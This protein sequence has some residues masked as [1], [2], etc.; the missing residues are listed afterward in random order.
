MADLGSIAHP[1]RPVDP[2][3]PLA[4]FPADPHRVLRALAPLLALGALAFLAG[5][6]QASARQ[7]NNGVDQER[8]ALLRIGWTPNDENVERRIRYDRL[9]AF[10]S[11][12]LG[13]PVT[14]V[15][16]ASYS[17]AIEA[18]RA[19]KLEVVGL[20]PFAYLIASSKQAAVP[21]VAPAEP[22]GSL[23]SYR[24][25][26]IVPPDSP[27]HTIDDLIARAGELTLSWTDPASTSGHLVPRAYL[28]DRGLNPE[29]DFKQTVFSLS[30]LVSVMTVVSHKVDVAAITN[31]G[32]ERL[33]E[34][35]RVKPGE[36]R[37]IWESEPICPSIIA[38]RSTLPPAFIEE[39][40]QAYLDFRHEDPE[41][42]ALF[43][44]VYLVPGIHWVPSHDRDFD[45]LRA[46]AR[47]VKHLELL[48]E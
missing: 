29:Q 40:R 34:S 32:L 18:L 23:R 9:T 2:V 42:W 37:V 26:F 45:E 41:G 1:P 19:R 38:V 36:V 11:R 20:G 43:E 12:K 16:T 14:M 8:P 27:I 28:E 10:L 3:I 30:H 48:A 21:L 22:D 39:L 5:C 35:G 31:T 6:G 46:L 25:A 4:R 7:E 17:P 33:L 15:E 44:Q 13:L 24:S 47:R